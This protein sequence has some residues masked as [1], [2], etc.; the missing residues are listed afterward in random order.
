MLPDKPPK[1]GRDLSDLLDIY[2]LKNLIEMPTRTGKTSETLLDLILIN[3][4]RRIL[5]SGVVDVH[6]SDHS[7]IYTFLRASAP[8]LRSRKV[9]LK[10]PKTF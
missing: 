5:T 9:C 8:R 10:K 2:N 3:N 7:L 1:D 4:V 6:L